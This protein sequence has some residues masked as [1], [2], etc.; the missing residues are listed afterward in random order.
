MSRPPRRGRKLRQ[1][2]RRRFKPLR[3]EPLEARVVLTGL[4]DFQGGE[5]ALLISSLYRLREPEP[6]QGPRSRELSRAASVARF[7]TASVAA[8]GP[9]RH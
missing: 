7:L 1:Q 6:P 4:S 9:V 3:L 5:D 8:V 2:K